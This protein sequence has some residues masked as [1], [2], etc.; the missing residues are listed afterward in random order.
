ME[1]FLIIAENN[2]TKP[3]IS[4]N[5]EDPGNPS[6][7]YIVIGS[8]SVLGFLIVTMVIIAILIK[9]RRA[10]E[11]EVE[12][13]SGS[14]EEMKRP[15]EGYTNKRGMADYY[16]NNYYDDMNYDRYYYG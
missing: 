8:C 13:G 16:T 6:V 1:I 5:E 12:M 2:K 7:H 4:G 15:S 14:V 3:A 11:N 9:R 10:K